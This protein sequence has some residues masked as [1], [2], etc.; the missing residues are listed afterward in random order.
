MPTH[1]HFTLQLQ[2][3]LLPPHPYTTPAGGRG[4]LREVWKNPSSIWVLEQFLSEPLSPDNSVQ[5]RAY[6]D[7]SDPREFG[8]N[9]YFVQ[10]YSGFFVPPVTSL[11]TFGIIS[12]DLSRL[13]VSPT[14]DSRDM[15]LVAFADQ[16]T[17]NSWTFYDT[18]TSEPMMMEQGQYYYMEMY[19][20]NGAGVYKCAHDLLRKLIRKEHFCKNFTTCIINLFCGLTCN[21]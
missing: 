8:E 6:R 3:Y 14:A 17:R 10:R 21:E 13:Y 5:E 19:S 11:Y 7:N 20:N 18:Q 12:D 9:T 1:H 16:Y 15:R 4:L 2:P